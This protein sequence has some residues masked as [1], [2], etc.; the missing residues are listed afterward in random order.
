VWIW[1]RDKRADD[2]NII[3]N[4]AI[5]RTKIEKKRPE[6]FKNNLLTHFS[7]LS[8]LFLKMSPRNTSNGSCGRKR[9]GIFFAAVKV[10]AVVI[11]SS[12]FVIVMMDVWDKYNTRRTSTGIQ[13]TP[14]FTLLAVGLK[15]IIFIV[16]T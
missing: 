4:C 5:K 1:Q 13:V 12:L 7:F 15:Y 10:L 16:A 9:K 14:I 6:N 8:I 3:F 2:S 11:C